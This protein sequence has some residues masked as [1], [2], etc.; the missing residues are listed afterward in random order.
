MAVTWLLTIVLKPLVALVMFGLIA[1]P[2]MLAFRRWFP[3]CRLKK[4]LLRPLTKRSAG[5][6]GWQ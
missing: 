5:S 1:L 3:E 6:R 2:L 4:V